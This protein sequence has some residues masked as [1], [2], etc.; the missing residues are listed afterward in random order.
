MLELHPGMRLLFAEVP[1]DVA[2]SFRRGRWP[3]RSP[4]TSVGDTGRL[5]TMAPR[6]WLPRRL[7]PKGDRSLG[8]QVLSAARQLGFGRPVL[9]LNDTTFAAL[10]SRTGWPVVYDVTDDWLLAEVGPRERRRRQHND[11]TVMQCA[12]E[13]VVCSPSLLA[14][15]GRTRPV[16]L[17]SNGVDLEA[18]RAPTRRPT[19]LPAG[20]VLLYQ[21]TLSTDRLD[22]DLCVALAA[23]VSGRATVVFVGP[24]SL[25]PTERQRLVGAGAVLLGPRPHGEVPGYL[26]HADVLVV[27]HS[28]T[29]FVESL[30]PIKAREFLA[31]GRPVVATPVAGFRDRDPPI[32][33]AGPETFVDTVRS[34][35]DR[36]P[37]PPGPG[38]LLYEPATWVAQAAAFLA[39]LEMAATDQPAA[40]AAPEV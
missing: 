38:P 21:G 27:P 39:V 4:L 35:L 17:I 34:V 5:W 36:G 25:T 6:K 26:Q 33:T 28:A 19:D 9:W 1:I 20:R 31:V 30:D 2:W 23:G 14:S 13:V 22:V 32:T 12:S 18:L 7:W 15:R 8:T 3:R 37:V 24:D 10:P 40:P 16:H 11:A 29:P